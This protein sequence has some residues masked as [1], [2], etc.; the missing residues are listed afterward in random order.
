MSE[1][2]SLFL[3]ACSAGCTTGSTSVTITP[4]SG[5]GSQGDGRFL[6]DTDSAKT[7]TSAGTGGAI[8]GGSDSAQHASAQF[9]GTSFP[10]SIFLSTGQAIPSQ[11]TNIAPGTVTFPIATS[12]VPSGYATNTAAIGASSG[13][14]CVV[15]QTDSFDGRTI[16]KWHPIRSWMGRTCRWR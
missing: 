13:V 14:A 5:G 2:T 9:S 10:V 12:G 16:M 6:I 11:A 1:D 8:I 7:I 3:G 4:T 15:D